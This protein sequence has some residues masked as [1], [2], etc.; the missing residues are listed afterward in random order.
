LEDSSGFILLDGDIVATYSDA[1]KF[2]VN[3]ETF[4]T[5]TTVLTLE[6]TNLITNSGHVPFENY[7]LSP[8]TTP[9]KMGLGS[10][11]VVHEAIIDVR[12]TGDVALE[13]GTDTTGGNLV[14]NGTNGSSANAGENLD[15]EGATGITI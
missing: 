13:D 11:P 8:E 6:S 2:R 4:E 5:T 7:T 14:L 9:N 12:A 1:Q 10:L 3:L 15:L